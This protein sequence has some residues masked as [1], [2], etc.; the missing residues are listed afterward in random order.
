[1]RSLLEGEG[2]TLA[3]MLKEI[4]GS[5]DEDMHADDDDDANNDAMVGRVGWV[6]YVLGLFWALSFCF[7]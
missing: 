5:F 4:I 6:G 3:L 1:M 7:A 2:D